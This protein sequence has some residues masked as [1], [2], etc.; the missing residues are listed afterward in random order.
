MDER[1]FNQYF[2][3]HGVEIATFNMLYGTAPSP[4]AVV[5][6]RFASRYVAAKPENVFAFGPLL[7]AF[8]AE[9]KEGRVPLTFSF[10]HAVE[11]KP[12]KAKKS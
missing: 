10:D 3:E 5:F 7:E 9:L 12:A 8:K 1:V 11:D 2:Y 6:S 4:P